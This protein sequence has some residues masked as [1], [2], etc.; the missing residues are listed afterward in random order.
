MIFKKTPINWGTSLEVQCLGLV[1]LVQGPQVQPPGWGTPHT[2]WGVDKFFFFFFNQS[3][4]F[5]FRIQRNKCSKVKD[6]NHYV[7]IQFNQLGFSQKKKVTDL[8]PNK[9]TL[10]EDEKYPRRMEQDLDTPRKSNQKGNHCLNKGIQKQ[11]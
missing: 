1:L 2:P 9:A 5:I 11:L 8:G 6:R 10:R 7:S 4:G 3:V